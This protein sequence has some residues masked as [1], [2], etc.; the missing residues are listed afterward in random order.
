MDIIVSGLAYPENGMKSMVRKYD[1]LKEKL[2]SEVKGFS[3]IFGDM[4]F[5]DNI[6][7]ETNIPQM[8]NPNDILASFGADFSEPKTKPNTTTPVINNVD[9]DY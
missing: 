1:T 9:D 4:E 8:R 6:D 3:D 5:D 7:E 2:N